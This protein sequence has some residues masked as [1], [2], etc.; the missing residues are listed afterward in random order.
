MEPKQNVTS[1]RVM[2]MSDATWKTGLCASSIHDLVSRGLFPRPF[3][4]VPGGR[5]VG[6]LED[7]IDRWIYSRK[8]AS[9]QE[10]V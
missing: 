6:W 9:K 5:A 4:L 1:P 8:A 10:A 3:Q 7:D 2:R